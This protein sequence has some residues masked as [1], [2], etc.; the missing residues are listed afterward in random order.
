MIT[1]TNRWTDYISSNCTRN[2]AAGYNKKFASLNWFFHTA[3]DI[4]IFTV[5]TVCSPGWQLHYT[6]AVAEASNDC[7]QSLALS[8]LIQFRIHAMENTAAA[9]THPCHTQVAVSYLSVLA[10]SIS[11]ICS[12]NKQYSNIKTQRNDLK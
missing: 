8:L 6:H 11:S 7:M 2:K 10:T 4:I 3:N 1:T 9:R 12:S 5:C